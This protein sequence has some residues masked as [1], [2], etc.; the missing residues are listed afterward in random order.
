[1]T[2]ITMPF[3]DWV[4]AEVTPVKAGWNFEFITG[5]YYGIAMM[6]LALYGITKPF[7]ALV[8]PVSTMFNYFVQLMGYLNYLTE[9]PEHYALMVPLW[10]L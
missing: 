6:P 2:T 4:S 8:F 5:L 9:L 10:I 1:M 3:L 7:S